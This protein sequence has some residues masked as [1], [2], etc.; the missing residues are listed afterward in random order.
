MVSATAQTQLRASCICVGTAATTI[1]HR[2]RWLC[3]SEREQPPAFN[4]FPCSRILRATDEG[5]RVHTEGWVCDE[6]GTP[7]QPGRCHMW[8]HKMALVPAADSTIFKAARRNKEGRERLPPPEPSRRAAAPARQIDAVHDATKYLDLI[9]RTG[10][11]ARAK[12][13]VRRA[14]AGEREPL[15]NVLDAGKDLGILIDSSHRPPEEIRAE[16]MRKLRDKVGPRV[17][18]DI[19]DPEGAPVLQ[20]MTQ[21]DRGSFKTLMRQEL[22]GAKEVLARAR[23]KAQNVI[24]A[25]QNVGRTTV[26][27]TYKEG[28]QSIQV[29]SSME[30]FGPLVELVKIDG[31]F[32]V[33]F[34]DKAGPQTIQLGTHSPCVNVEK[35]INNQ[36]LVTPISVRGAGGEGDIVV[37]GT[38]GQAGRIGLVDRILN[39]SLSEQDARRVDFAALRAELSALESIG[40]DK[41]FAVAGSKIGAEQ[42][43]V[44]GRFA[45]DSVHPDFVTSFH[46]DA[47]RGVE[48]KGSKTDKQIEAEETEERADACFWNG[49]DSE[50]R[51]DPMKIF[52]C[53]LIDSRAECGLDARLAYTE[54]ARLFGRC[55]DLDSLHL[56]YYAKRCASLCKLRMF[57]RALDDA[58]MYERQRPESPTGHCL[59]GCVYDGLNLHNESIASFERSLDHAEIIPYDGS[60]IWATGTLVAEN[61]K[62]AIDRRAKVADR[63][64][65]AN[66]HGVKWR[67]LG[68]F[69]KA[70]PCLQEAAQLQKLCVG[71]NHL[72]YATCLNNLG[73]C[74]EAMGNYDDAMIQYKK[75]LV[76]SEAASPG[77]LRVSAQQARHLPY[78]TKGGFLRGSSW[79]EG[80]SGLK[81]VELDSHAQFAER[82]RLRHPALEE[83]LQSTS[84]LK[85]NCTGI[86]RPIHG[87]ELDNAGLAAILERKVNE[88]SN[89][90]FKV[91][92]WAEFAISDLRYD[93]FIEVGESYFQPERKTEF[94]HK[95][96]MA[97]GIQDLCHDHFVQSGSTCFV[98]A[99][100]AQSCDTYVEVEVVQGDNINRVRGPLAVRTR[101][102]V[103]EDP[104]AHGPAWNQILSLELPRGD[105]SVIVRLMGRNPERHAYEAAATAKRQQIQEPRAEL[106]TLKKELADKHDRIQRF[107]LIGSSKEKERKKEEKNYKELLLDVKPLDERIAKLSE[108]QHEFETLAKMP[109]LDD[110]I[111][112]Q[113]IYDISRLSKKLNGSD[114]VVSKEGGEWFETPDLEGHRVR[115]EDFGVAS[116]QVKFSWIPRCSEYA[117]R[118][119]NIGNLHRILGD[120]LRGGDKTRGGVCDDYKKL[121]VHCNLAESHLEASLETMLRAK[122]IAPP[123]ELSMLEAAKAKRDGIE[124]DTTKHVEVDGTHTVEYLQVKENLALLHYSRGLPVVWPKGTPESVKTAFDRTRA[125]SQTRA[126]EI[127]EEVMQ[128]RAD[129]AGSETEEF[130]HL[131]RILALQHIEK[132]NAELRKP[133]TT[134][135]EKRSL[136]RRAMDN[137]RDALPVQQRARELSRKL[138]GDKSNEV[139]R[140]MDLL[141]HLHLR[142]GEAQV[143]PGDYGSWTIDTSESWHWDIVAKI[144]EKVEVAARST[145]DFTKRE[146]E[147]LKENQA[148]LLQERLRLHDPPTITDYSAEGKDQ[149]A[150]LKKARAGAERKIKTRGVLGDIKI[151]KA[152]ATK[153]RAPDTTVVRMDLQRWPN[154]ALH[155][156]QS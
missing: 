86:E 93:D 154:P 12:S 9:E 48:K 73:A 138:F 107:R 144:D 105:E 53:A 84:G 62:Y 72:H 30:L 113:F 123:R 14:D 36:L 155:T 148:T 15:D 130:L 90:D 140:D 8:S 1:P 142:L 49:I 120:K 75:S 65:V 43:D 52:H 2:A 134:K 6:V 47:R 104:K 19:E 88:G 125:K 99:E 22:R 98:P 156:A 153:F 91:A 32:T 13:L 145:H 46:E 71:E 61:L 74:L 139:A 151:S 45:Q 146:M 131:L 28:A 76:I 103:T 44:G 121:E 26:T 95:E 63:A 77:E 82:R 17:R 40:I 141:S 129:L 150:L 21:L 78:V 143:I 126:V 152:K 127:L 96:W 59:L 147:M 35:V 133:G 118:L 132:G 55:I 4:Q 58:K 83:A 97:F 89:T 16:I 115:G 60:R 57:S 80:A 3:A 114:R 124:I 94:T 128:L 11:E 110:R 112:G 54:A 38:C 41:D 23:A 100:S 109:H 92:E 79:V 149:D 117:T 56:T 122:S 33:Q 64:R 7:V 5:V 136:A 51:D 102:V 20:D 68:E 34:V 106:E 87:R 116:L 108:E 42:S 67:K 85:W 37:F 137:F 31:K 25:E 10:A 29:T 39:P 18:Q 27:K 119:C 50:K 24:Q 101:V 81:W 111:I 66:Q 70:I 69:G 135:E